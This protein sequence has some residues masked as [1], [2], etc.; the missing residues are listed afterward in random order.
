MFEHTYTAPAGSVIERSTEVEGV[1]YEAGTHAAD[2]TY[3]DAKWSAKSVAIRSEEG[4][5]TVSATMLVESA[6]GAR[7]A[8][9]VISQ[10]FSELHIPADQIEVMAGPDGSMVIP[11]AAIQGLLE[12]AIV[13]AVSDQA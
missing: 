8:E 7:L 9:T 5:Y 6:D 4:G 10:P 11:M 2:T 13:S 3:D 1:L 12:A